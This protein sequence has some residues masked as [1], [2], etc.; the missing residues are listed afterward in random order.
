MDVERWILDDGRLISVRWVLQVYTLYLI[1]ML[2]PC[3]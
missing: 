1:R 3:V 2:L